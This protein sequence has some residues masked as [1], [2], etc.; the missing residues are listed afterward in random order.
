MCPLLWKKIYSSDLDFFSIMILIENTGLSWWTRRFFNM[1]EIIH[2]LFCCYAL[3][4]HF[5]ALLA[6]IQHCEKKKNAAYK[7]SA[8]V[9]HC[10]RHSSSPGFIYCV[11]KKMSI[12]VTF[13]LKLMFLYSASEGDIVKQ[14]SNYCLLRYWNH[15]KWSTKRG[16]YLYTFNLTV[17][18]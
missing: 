17:S 3:A 12:I 9:A 18:C 8:F 1:K 14:P 16:V 6:H 7:C 10:F 5:Q 15:K 4:E 2:E 13:I 11:E